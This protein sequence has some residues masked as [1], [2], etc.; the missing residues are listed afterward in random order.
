MT[1]K[2]ESDKIWDEIKDLP[3]AMFALSSQ[4]VSHHVERIDLDPNI[5]H[6]RTKSSAVVASLDEALNCV[7]DRAG[8]VRRTDAYEIEQAE[9]GFVVVK[10]GRAKLDLVKVKQELDKAKAK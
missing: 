7:A 9:G 3:I 4:T 5:V 6:L 1:T 8:N 2:K 10:R